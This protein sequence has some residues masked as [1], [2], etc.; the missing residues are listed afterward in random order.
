MPGALLSLS[1]SSTPATFEKFLY[2][3]A[4]GASLVYLIISIVLLLPTGLLGVA[5]IGLA[6][7]G[8]IGSWRGLKA[9]KAKEA[10]SAPPPSRRDAD[11]G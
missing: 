4:F 11:V 3:A 1:M 2:Q 5:S 8:T 10:A 6:T 7:F 9:V